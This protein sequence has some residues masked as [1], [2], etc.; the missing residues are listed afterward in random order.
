MM[1]S[2]HDESRR[3]T[4]RSR[5]HGLAVG[6]ALLAA[7]LLLRTDRAVEAARPGELGRLVPAGALLLLESDDLPALAGRWQ[8]CALRGE[9]EG[10]DVYSR[11]TAS[12]LGLRLGE[13]VAELEATLDEPDLSM[14]RLSK[15][16]GGR[17]GLALYSIGETRFVLWLRTRRG[18]AEDL[19][20]LRP[21]LETSRREVAGHSYLVHAGVPG[22]TSTVGVGVVGDLLIASNDLG[23]LEKAMRLAAGEAGESLASD[24]VYGQLAGKAPAAAT[25]HLY[26]DMERIGA[27]RAFQRYWV[28]DNA[29]ELAG[30]GRAMLSVEWRDGETVEH[31]LLAYRDGGTRLDAGEGGAPPDE[32][33]AALPEGLY[34]SLHETRS[35]EAAAL[36]AR[37]LWPGEPGDGAPPALAA[38]LGPARPARCVEV[39]RLA[40]RDGFAPSDDLAVALLLAEPTALATAAVVDGAAEAMAR[41]LSAGRAV[42]PSRAERTLS[43]VA[44]TTVAA[45]LPG[46][47][48][49]TL[50]RSGDGAVLVL[51]SSAAL[52][53]QL[54]TA[55]AEAEPLGRELRRPGP[56]A[57]RAD[58][59]RADRLLGRRLVLATKATDYGP[60]AFFGQD[61]PELL[62]VPRIARIERLAWREGAFD[63]QLV[64]YLSP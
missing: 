6:A 32:R 52:A 39:A 12:R 51:A 36:A 42:T 9:L 16:P 21:D 64:R 30:L 59:G 3:A 31:R 20:L 1:P 37:W 18:A 45:P 44:T 5:A 27:T 10:T 41:A 56:D 53:A 60:E 26:L 49:L 11:C 63:H 43:G 50:A 57:A 24:P 48:E 2:T 47:P 22:E 62:A 7:L 15:L 46:G 34:A 29:A 8:D 4:A 33:L 19:R 54:A 38:L 58:L 13:R 55:A 28:H 61:V 14:G 25:A 40:S 23:Q 17:G 35:A